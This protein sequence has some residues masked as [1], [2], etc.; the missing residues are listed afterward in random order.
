MVCRRSIAQ[1]SFQGPRN[2]TGSIS[3]SGM[4]CR[5][6]QFVAVSAIGYPG[7]HERQSR[8]QLLE[9]TRA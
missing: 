2:L 3:T 4:T 1:P 8:Y 6:F 9:F 7:R 5:G